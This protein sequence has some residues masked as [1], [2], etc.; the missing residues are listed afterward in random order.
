MKHCNS[1]A[2]KQI[3]LFQSGQKKTKN[4]LGEQNRG[5]GLG[6]I[7]APPAQV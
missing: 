6:E 2:S 3:N 7:V 4:S 5:E 1:K